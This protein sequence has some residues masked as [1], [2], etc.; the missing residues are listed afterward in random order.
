METI[1]DVWEGAL[2]IDE[3]LLQLENVHAIIIR[4]N[5][6]NGGH[7][8]DEN[9]QNQWDQAEYF[10]RAP[11]FVYNP[12]VDGH[13]NAQWMLSHL[14]I[15]GVTRVFI[16][17]EVT[18]IGYSS[19]VYADQLQICIN[20]IKQVYPKTTIYTGG[21][22]LPIVAH[23]PANVDYWWARYPYTLCPQGDRQYWSWEK[24]RTTSNTYGF[25]P[26]LEHKCPGQISAWQCSGDKLILPGCADRAIDLTLFNGDLNSLQ[27]WWG[28]ILPTLS[29][30][31]KVNIMW[32]ELQ[33]HYPNWNW[34][35]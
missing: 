6:I 33:L 19:E 28:A 21:W 1:L 31:N 5:D 26:D 16:D 20:E 12:W 23:W 14:P 35:V 2:D 10:L 29:L 8:L 30:Q 3:G 22:F 32:R 17:V 34:Q 25:H 15:I 27:N 18:K 11:Y 13:T 7:H 24:W 4:L 9:F